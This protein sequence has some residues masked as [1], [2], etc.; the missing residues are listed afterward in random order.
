MGLVHELKE[1]VDYRLQEL[2]M[3]FEEAW[4]LADD[5]HDVRGNDGFVILAA[6]NLT[7]PKEILDDDDKEALLVVLV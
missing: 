6:L 5:V 4:I 3:R 1:L 2:P 7:Q